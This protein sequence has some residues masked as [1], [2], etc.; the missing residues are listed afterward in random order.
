ML[1]IASDKKAAIA[2]MCRHHHVRRLDIFG[3]AAREACLPAASD[4]DFLVE[5]ENLPEGVYAD[6]YFSLLESLERLFERPVDLVVADCLRNP[7]LKADID[8]H[9]ALLYAA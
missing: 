4:I 8:R 7:F 9:K 6:N 5:F 3:S 1:K 2:T